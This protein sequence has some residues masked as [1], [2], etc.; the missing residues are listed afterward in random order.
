VRYAHCDR[1][2]NW[3]DAIL[4]RDSLECLPEQSVAVQKIID[5][6]YESAA[7]GREVRIAPGPRR[8]P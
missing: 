6:I 3:L 8:E 1:I 4:G 5:A 2:H 7:S